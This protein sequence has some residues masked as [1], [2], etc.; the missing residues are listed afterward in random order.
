MLLSLLL[1]AVAGIAFGIAL[2]RGYF[3][4]EIAAGKAELA[5]IEAAAKKDLTTAETKVKVE[6]DKL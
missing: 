5:K 4:K 1:V 3:S 2:T 6:I